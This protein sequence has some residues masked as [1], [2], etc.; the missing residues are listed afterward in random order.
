MTNIPSLI[1]SILFI[2]CDFDFLVVVCAGL[3]SNLH[4]SFP[5]FSAYLEL[6][7]CMH[8]ILGWLHLYVPLNR[9]MQAL[10]LNLPINLCKTLAHLHHGMNCRLLVILILFS[11]FSPVR[12]QNIKVRINATRD[13]IVLKFL[14]PNAYTKLEGYILGYGGNMFS[15]QF[16]Q[17]PEDG[18]PY[19][20]E[21]GKSLHMCL[22]R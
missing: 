16:I 14:L 22:P 17:L 20:G 7:N 4:F 15:K 12:H 10:L 5:T 3:H 9:N 11:S 2:W 6:V 8:I 19:E 1:F 21:F 18:Q 13:T